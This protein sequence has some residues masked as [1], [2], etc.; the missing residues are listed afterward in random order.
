MGAG[1]SSSALEVIEEIKAKDPDNLYAC[2]VAAYIRWN[3]EEYA[4]ALSL[5]EKALPKVCE[6][7][8]RLIE[9]DLRDTLGILSLRTGRFDKACE[10]AERKISLF[11]ENV[12]SRLIIALSSFSSND[13]KKYEEN[14]SKAVEMGISDPAFQ[15]RL[16]SLLEDREM[17]QK[18]YIRSLLDRARYEQ[19]LNEKVWM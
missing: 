3:A 17:L 15:I 16:N 4:E 18:L 10:Q 11:G 13:D 12:L 6:G 2:L 9:N 1:N 14:L 19:R 7:G 5:Y 8:Y